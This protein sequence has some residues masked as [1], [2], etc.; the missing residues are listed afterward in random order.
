VPYHAAEDLLD[1]VDETFNF[2]PLWLCPLRQTGRSPYSAYG[3]TAEAKPKTGA[4]EMLLNFGV[5]G[6]GPTGRDKFVEV[7]RCLEHKV[8]E[9]KGQK[10]LYAQ[11]YYTETEFWDIYDRK[12]YDSMR[13]KYHASYLPSLYD[14]VKVDLSRERRM[15]K[16]WI[17]WLVALL[18]SV[19]PLSG[20]Y[21]V[22]QTIVGHEYLLPGKSIWDAKK[23]E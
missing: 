8:H 23:E 22:F 1:F 13:E 18:W 20:L 12:E 14:K 21:G 9:L 17:G 15:D 4:P 16:T 7:N 2:F 6:P 19:W 5:W 11:A 3:L 10:W